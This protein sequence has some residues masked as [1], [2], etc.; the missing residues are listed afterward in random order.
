MYPSKRARIDTWCRK[1]EP[2]SRPAD[3]GCAILHTKGKLAEFYNFGSMF[4]FPRCPVLEIEPGRRPTD[5]WWRY[6]EARMRPGRCRAPSDRSPRHQGSIRG[7]ENSTNGEKNQISA[8]SQFRM[9]AHEVYQDLDRPVASGSSHIMRSGHLML[10][11]RLWHELM[12]SSDPQ[13][14]PSTALRP[15]AEQKTPSSDGG[16]I[17]GI[18]GPRAGPR[19]LR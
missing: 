9:K 3:D 11:G 10:G 15:R 1:M 17:R 4:F 8:I 2:T 18:P 16:P 6:L 12:P 5:L 14:A 19:P 7:Q 13:E